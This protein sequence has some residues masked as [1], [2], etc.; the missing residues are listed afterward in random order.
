V[1][2]CSSLPLG[3]YEVG[4]DGRLARTAIAAEAEL[5]ATASA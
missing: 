1:L 4:D 2:V 5:G 3:A